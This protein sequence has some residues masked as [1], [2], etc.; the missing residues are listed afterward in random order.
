MVQAKQI[1][2]MTTARV[3]GT[4]KST[5]AKKDP[6]VVNLS[7]DESGDD[8]SGED[9]SGEDESGDDESGD[10]ESGDDESGDDES[11]DD[12]SGDDESGEDDEEQ[13]PQ[14]SVGTKPRLPKKIGSIATKKPPRRMP[15]PSPSPSPPR[16][17]VARKEP[18]DVGM[19]EA[20]GAALEP[21][22]A[23]S[24]ESPDA[25][26]DANADADAGSSGSWTKPDRWYCSDPR[27]RTDD[28]LSMGEFK[29]ALDSILLPKG[30][31]FKERY[32]PMELG[33][34]ITGPTGL[35][36]DMKVLF[37][38]GHPVLAGLRT[39]ETGEVRMVIFV[40]GPGHKHMKTMP[41]VTHVAGP[42]AA[43]LLSQL[44]VASNVRASTVHWQT[45]VLQR[46]VVMWFSHVHWGL[47]GEF[48][49]AALGRRNQKIFPLDVIALP[50]LTAAPA[51]AQRVLFARLG[52]VPVGSDANQHEREW[53]LSESALPHDSISKSIAEAITTTCDQR[54]MREPTSQSS[55]WSRPTSLSIENAMRQF[56]TQGASAA[57]ASQSLADIA[58]SKLQG[59]DLREMG[60]ARSRAAALVAASSRKR[61]HRKRTA[62]EREYSNDSQCEEA[63]SQWESGDEDGTGRHTD[64]APRRP[65]RVQTSSD[66]DD[67]GEESEN[68]DDRAF[69]VVN[70][71]ES[72]DESESAS[73]QGSSD[74]SSDEDAGASR[75]TRSPRLSEAVV[76][77]ARQL[78]SK[79][80][81]CTQVL[82]GHVE[83]DRLELLAYSAA[84][85]NVEGISPVEKHE[86]VL[87]TFQ[88]AATRLQQAVKD[89]TCGREGP[90][91]GMRAC[92]EAQSQL[93][94]FVTK[95]AVFQGG[96]L[97]Q[98]GTGAEV[99]ESGTSERQRMV[100]GSLHKLCSRLIA[101]NVRN[102]GN[103][104]RIRDAVTALD[105]VVGAIE[106]SNKNQRPDIEE[107][108][109]ID[110]GA[111]PLG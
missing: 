15:S 88:L 14:P 52:E 82:L 59:P 54:A 46:A 49:P 71:E 13:L 33:D 28:R 58:R 93:L 38:N 51:Q 63:D 57:I 37:Y 40:D 20:S 103:A 81:Q 84:L 11:G 34:L 2:A 9:E 44:R 53:F 55:A 79:A 101:E 35:Y 72:P 50:K 1:S 22:R 76:D 42:H 105:E 97:R 56:E 106:R 26:A 83:Q 17:L 31:G 16:K 110:G 78:V 85:A 18:A 91:R 77:D 48:S 99:G 100:D 73:Y 36:I 39:S 27:S 66:D 5:H 102:S 65:R 47:T 111:S 61:P 10:D 96:R 107:M 108:L 92:I 67:E 95:I 64:K 12:E 70:G 60:L 89:S 43:V 30:R 74:E 86:S 3:S 87:Q 45:Y 41:H 21:A 19:T 24:T 94:E 69:A 98:V 68:S 25:D 8:E 29:S 32:K 6:P 90:C 23:L 4:S 62:A 104:K 7:D 75:S 109:S 80:E